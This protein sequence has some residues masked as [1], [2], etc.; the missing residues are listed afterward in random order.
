MHALTAKGK[1]KCFNVMLIEGRA[2]KALLLYLKKIL[3]SKMPIS[4]QTLASL[5]VI[6]A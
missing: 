3:P 4:F 2:L 1:K 5:S 6:V